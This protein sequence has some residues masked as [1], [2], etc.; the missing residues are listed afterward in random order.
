MTV[1][2]TGAAQYN[3]NIYY[4]LS[5]YA[6]GRAWVR[7]TA[8][9]DLMQYDPAGGPEKLWYAFHAPAFW[10]PQLPLPCVA[11]AAVAKRD[12]VAQAPAGVFSPSL[13]I[14][15]APGV[16]MDAGLQEE[17][18]APGV[19]LV[20]RV[21]TTIAG[22]RVHELIFARISGTAIT[23]PELSFGLAIDRPVYYANLMP[24]IDPSQVAPWLTARLTIRNTT[25]LPL[26]LQFNSGQQYDLAIRDASGRQVF[27][28][29]EGKA[30]TQALTRL[31]LSPGE[32]SFVV[33]ARL[34]DRSGKPFPEGRY[35]AEAWLTT[36]GEKVYSATVAFELR[37]TY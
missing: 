13:V 14:S 24:P 37:Y 25:A 12:A 19:G 8:A 15:Y 18:F 17:T 33:E 20:R 16:C 11:Q 28:W 23:G 6:A 29:S 35:T 36:S 22:P 32:K 30:F 3:G 21:D 7:Q 27:L 9:G 4:E 2:A 31:D 5:G 26:M 10:Q 34:A 1:E